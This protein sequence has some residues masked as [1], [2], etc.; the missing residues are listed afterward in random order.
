MT[1]SEPIYSYIHIDMKNPFHPFDLMCFV[2]S[3]QPHNQLPRE[4]SLSL[5]VSSLTSVPYTVYERIRNE[6]NV[7][8][9]Y[10]GPFNHLTCIKAS[11]FQSSCSLPREGSV[12]RPF[13]PPVTP[14]PD[15]IQQANA[16]NIT[17]N[18]SI[19]RYL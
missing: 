18:G 4:K 12:G 13:T 9:L 16:S 19:F 5:Y 6:A 3:R 8:Q 1:T 2:F 10:T 17:R 7:L 14:V 15:T 11:P